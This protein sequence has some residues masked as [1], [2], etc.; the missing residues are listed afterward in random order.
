MPNNIFFSDKESRIAGFFLLEKHIEA[1]GFIEYR[2][3]G[4]FVG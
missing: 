4:I 3:A 2:E 1:A